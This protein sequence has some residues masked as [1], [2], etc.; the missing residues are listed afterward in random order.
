MSIF[1]GFRNKFESMFF[2]GSRQTP[3]IGNSGK[4]IVQ[5]TNAELASFFNLLKE[6]STERSK[7]Y[8]DYKVMLNDA[9]TRAAVKLF[10]EDATQMDAVKNRVLWVECPVDPVWEEK[11][12]SFLWNN[13]KVDKIIRSLAFYTAAYGDCFLNTFTQDKEYLKTN[14]VG[15][16]FEV[17]PPINVMEVQRFGKT[18]GFFVDDK[19]EKNTSKTTQNV[20]L[21]TTNFIHFSL[22]QGFMSQK[23]QLTDVDNVTGMPTVDS[24]LVV[25]GESLLEAARA[26]FRLR[27]LFDFLLVLSRYNK[28]SFYRLFGVEVG[29]SDNKEANAILKEFTDNI[30]TRRSMDL[31]LGVLNQQAAPMQT[32]GNIY[33]TTRDGKGNVSVE[34]IGGDSNVRGLED[35]NYFDDRYYGALSVPKQFLGQAKE[36]PGGISD[37]TLT[38]LDIK[39]GRTVKT[40]QAALINGFEELVF[41]K[42]AVID[43]REAPPPFKVCMAP[44]ATVDEEARQNEN[45]KK[46]ERL[47]S[48]LDAVDKLQLAEEDGFNKK[49]VAKYLIKKFA[50]DPALEDIMFKEKEKKKL[51]NPVGEFGSSMGGGDSGDGLNFGGNEFGGSSG[52]GL[53]EFGHPEG[54]DLF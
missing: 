32:G 44:I 36:L 53:G 40:L 43:K 54:R 10:V 3:A 24:Y 42:T 12:N 22:N 1:T 25:L 17:E 33:Y 35:I 48:I 5:L 21:D 52:G 18:V 20:L 29:N 31:F 23:I 41:W 7:R 26:D 2:R 4:Q 11:T 38:R 51:E 34:T 28:S 30:E 47:N 13:V 6:V 45:Q 9:I 19:D 15:D 39:Y 46:L 37:S 8:Q 16:F 14:V 27:Q 50:D 49:E